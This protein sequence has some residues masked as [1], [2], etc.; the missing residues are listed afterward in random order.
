[1]VG[2]RGEVGA[3]IAAIESAMLPAGGGI[4]MPR[5]REL[6]GR[7]GFLSP[8]ARAEAAKLISAHEELEWVTCDAADVEM[9]IAMRMSK[10]KDRAGADAFAEQRLAKHARLQEEAL[11]LGAEV[12]RLE[13]V[14]WGL[15]DA[16]KREI[17]ELHQ[18]A[19]RLSACFG[20]IV[21]VGRRVL[22]APREGGG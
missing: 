6:V 9:I 19:V 20:Q 22:R 7:E 17:A 2:G 16:D 14:V 11:S 21:M 4:C 5:L 15:L 8:R 1:M 10:D 3:A 12:S 13:G 18:F